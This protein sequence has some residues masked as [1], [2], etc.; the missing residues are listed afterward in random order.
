M[1][2][3]ATGSL[4]KWDLTIKGVENRSINNLDDISLMFGRAFN[5]MENE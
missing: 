5:S 4:Y 3:R 1:H 2:R